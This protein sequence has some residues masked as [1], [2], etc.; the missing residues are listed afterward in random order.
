MHERIN[1]LEAKMDSKMSALE[2]SDCAL[3]RWNRYRCHRPSDRHNGYSSSI[4]VLRSRILRSEHLLF[5]R[6]RMLLPC[7]RVYDGARI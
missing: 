2:T 3:D 6:L 7:Q 4:L 5:Y 1:A